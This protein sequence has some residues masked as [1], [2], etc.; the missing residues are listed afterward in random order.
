LGFN[1]T[2]GTIPTGKKEV[3]S[4]VSDGVWQSA[5]ETGS[6]RNNLSALSNEY[7]AKNILKFPY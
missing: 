3:L 7:G 5:R 6:I 4:T 1:V 2:Y